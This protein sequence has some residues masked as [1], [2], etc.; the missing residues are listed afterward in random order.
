MILIIVESPAK[1][2]K[3]QGF[4]NKNYIVKSS[5]GHFV[6]LNTTKLD[7]MIKENFNPVYQISSNK[8]KIVKDLKSIKTK[9]IILA[10]DDD[11]EGDG[12]AW[13]CGNL[14]K[15]NFNEKNRIVFNEISKKS[16]LKALE[17]P[18]NL[19]LNSVNAQR[20]RQLIDLMIGFKLSPLLWKHIKTHV[21]GLSAGRVQSC[22]L[23]ILIEHE[24]KIN[25]FVGKKEYKTDGEF[26]IDKY[27]LICDFTFLEKKYE[28]NDILI[29]YDKLKINKSFNIKSMDNKI[30]KRYPP[31]PFVTSSLQQS[32]QNEF[33]FSVSQT[34]QIAQKLYVNGKITYIRT[35]S[36]FISEDFHENLKQNI[37]NNYGEEYYKKHMSNKKIKGAQEAHEAIRPINLE[38]VLNDKY[39]ECDK[40]LY[41]LILKR[42]IISNMK[43]AE[44]DTYMYNLTNKNID[45]YGSFNGKEKFLIFKG[46]LVYDTDKK[47]DNVNVF[48]IN[49][50]LQ[51]IESKCKLEEENPPQYLNESSIVKRLE[52][53]GIGRPSTYTSSVNTLYNR[54]YTEVKDIESQKKEREIITLDKNDNIN[55]FIEEYTLP[56]Q[57]KR[58]IVTDL[59][60][61]VLKYLLT[62]FSN[63]INVEFTSNVES[64]LDKVSNGEL[65]WNI[66]IK[67]I[68]DSFITIVNEQSKFRNLKRDEKVFSN[69]YTLNKGAYGFYI[70]DDER[71]NY[72]INYYLKYYKLSVNQLEDKHV[73]SLVKYPKKI[74]V[75]ENKTVIM[76]LGP[77]GY[78]IDYNGKN[79]KVK[80]KNI[81]FN[82][83][84]RML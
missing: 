14:L 41:N 21:K 53:T 1:A 10:S 59:G 11:R 43:P 61:I 42:T 38:E 52:T 3:I 44:Y 75:Y 73:K 77:Y 62:H 69:K 30:E 40:K 25:N 29:L 7:L 24:D 55:E 80:H 78:Y 2:K 70:Q 48:K 27:N 39:T 50:K 49:D 5:C 51:L 83:F 22:L 36:T 37:K 57:K 81:K 17:N 76:K 84:I 33:G 26:I 19:N 35:D 15:L 32:A 31:P 74:G 20:T 63:I 65:N 72:N 71:N 8:S 64:D 12:I 34:D 54:N 45:K 79:Y 56:K 9:E 46:Y 23:R 67:K 60:K 47:L 58:I 66:V 18:I 68:Y 13:H 16:I 6:E 4:L 82:D 28:K